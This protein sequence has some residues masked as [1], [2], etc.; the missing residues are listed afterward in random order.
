MKILLVTAEVA[1]YVSVGGLSQVMYFLPNA[2]IKR[3]HDVRIFTP[4]YGAM[5]A[6]EQNK[7]KWKLE[8]VMEGLSVK[9]CSDD[10]KGKQKK[11][12][13]KEELVCNVKMHQSKKKS[14]LVYFL[15]NRE[16]YELRANVF[17]YADDHIRFALLSKGC[18]EW[19][20]AAYQ[21]DKDTWW[22]D[23]IQCNDW[24]TGYLIELAKQDSRY[25]NL[26]AKTAII[27]TIHNFSFQ[28]NYD[29]R[30]AKDGEKDIGTTPLDSFF[31]PEFQRQNALLR[32]MQYA[33]AINTVSPTHAV[34]VLT[35]EY[36]EGL[37]MIL[38]KSRGKLIGILNGLDTKEFNPA[39]DLIIKINYDEKTFSKARRE[40]KME[41]QSLFSLEKNATRP[42][43]AIAGRLSQQKGWDILLEMLPRLFE[44]RQDVQLIILGGGDHSYREKVQKLHETYP[45]RVGIHLYADFRLPRKIFAGADMMLMPS[46][47]EP[48]GIVALEALRYGSVPVVRRTGGLND[49]IQDF[50]PNTGKGNGFSFVKKDS[51]A[52]F[53]AVVEA[54]TIFKQ[55]T[56]WKK[57]VYNCMIADFS[58]EHAAKEYEKWYIQILE[59]KKRAMSLT[60]HPA[61]S[62]SPVV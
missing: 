53:A 14:P 20:F 1:P 49:V 44:H 32:G 21:I 34:E 60:P 17:G 45:D 24:H 62:L 33:D 8:M 38:L 18:L 46:S 15:E 13:Y 12:Q 4:K 37:D 48:G 23:I 58:W 59:E 40:N 7:N 30:Y 19:L 51:W 52:L 26:F 50:N 25:K 36:S 6:Y 11:E 35:K 31:T 57:V 61:Y 5:D 10:V 56:L 54:L 3:G 16:Y 47:F 9:T 41:L 29:F 43:L 28:G 42:L 22:P 39:T 55:P 2:L 27:Y